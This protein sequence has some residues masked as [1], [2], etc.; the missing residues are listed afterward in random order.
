MTYPAPFLDNVG[1]YPDTLGD[2]RTW[3]RAHQWVQ[4]L[5]G[6]RVFFRL[7]D[8]PTFPCVR[9]YDAG[10]TQQPGE[11]PIVDTQVGIDV[12]GG[13]YADVV[14]ITRAIAAACH[15][16]AAGTLIGSTT[17]VLNADPGTVVDSPDPDTG[18][19]RKVLT[20][21][22]TVRAVTANG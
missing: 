22:F 4:P 13:A 3:L 19:P 9:I 12:W 10:T 6:G 15:M 17:V 11:V 7:P 1:V 21:T 14:A 18:Q 20:A 16:L 2:V 5:V 8:S